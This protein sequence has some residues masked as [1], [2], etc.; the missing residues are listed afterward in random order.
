MRVSV[1]VPTRNRTRTL[2]LCLEAVAG[3]PGHGERFEVIVVDDGSCAGTRAEN[4]VLCAKLGCR[5]EAVDRSRG[6]AHARNRGAVLSRSE[7]LCF[8]DDDVCAEPA[9][10]ENLCTQIAFAN[11]EVV[12]VEGRTVPR[13]EGLWDSEVANTSGG[14][15]L[16]SNI[17]YRR[18]AFVAVGGFNEAFTGPFCEDHELATRM[19][20]QGRI[21]F[22]PDVSV[23][24]LPRHVTAFGLVTKAPRRM[25]QLLRSE[26]TFYRLHPGRYG[27]FRHAASFAGTCTA[28]LLKHTYTCLRRRT[29][30]QIRN[31]PRQALMLGLASSI[32]QACAWFYVAPLCIRALRGRERTFDPDST[33]GLTA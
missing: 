13:G 3:Q 26:Q 10:A 28:V 18:D 16:T 14:L 19:L 22:A 32:E 15:Y 20:R 1:V 9:F 8:M 29:W 27:T 25:W 2:G 30:K 5:Y 6:P 31:H 7:W 12:G 17:S 23:H 21:V 11:R 24:H 4:A 33:G